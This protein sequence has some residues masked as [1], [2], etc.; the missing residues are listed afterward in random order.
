MA[1]KNIDNLIGPVLADP[2][3]RANV[4]RERAEAVAEILAFN[5]AE[6]RKA[7]AVTQMELAAALARGQSS[8][9]ALEHSEDPKL[10]SLREYVEALGGR[11]EV[12]AVIDG[13]RFELKV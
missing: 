5:L 11:L 10:S 12:A 9:S 3:R 4:E 13:E 7:R 1:F 8:V 2:A 6:L